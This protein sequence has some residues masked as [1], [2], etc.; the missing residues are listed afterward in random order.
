M[1]TDES[2]IVTLTGATF[3]SFTDHF[4]TV[5]IT[6]DDKQALE[7]KHPNIEFWPHFEA[8]YNDQ[9]VLDRLKAVE[10]RGRYKGKSA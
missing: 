1:E 6:N 7:A 9:H 10:K 8:A 4:A 3:A 5:S 2:L